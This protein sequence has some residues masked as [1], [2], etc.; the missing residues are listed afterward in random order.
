MKQY[1]YKISES[2][3]SIHIEVAEWDPDRWDGEGG[4]R[5]GY[6]ATVYAYERLLAW[7]ADDPEATRTEWEV[8][9]NM[10]SMSVPPA[11]AAQR[12]RIYTN[13]ANAGAYLEWRLAARHNPGEIIAEL[14]REVGSDPRGYFH[15]PP[16]PWSTYPDPLPEKATS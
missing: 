11:E 1:I 2:G 15:F 8:T 6:E 5:F 14:Q 7:K 12:A 9:V 4:A 16:K 13:A 10:G 3:A